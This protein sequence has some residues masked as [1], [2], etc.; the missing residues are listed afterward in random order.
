[1]HSAKKTIIR[2]KNKDWLPFGKLLAHGKKY[3]YFKIY[4]NKY[5]YSQVFLFLLY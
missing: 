5:R 2:Y 1:M 3:F 4:E